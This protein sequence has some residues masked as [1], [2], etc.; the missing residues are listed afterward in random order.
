MSPFPLAFFP[1]TKH[2]RNAILA[3]QLEKNVTRSGPHPISLAADSLPVQAYILLLALLL[4]PHPLYPNPTTKMAPK[5]NNIHPS[6]HPTHASPSSSSSIEAIITSL[7]SRPDTA[8]AAATYHSSIRTSAAQ[9]R[10][11]LPSSPDPTSPAAAWLPIPEA[12]YRHASRFP[13]RVSTCVDLFH[14]IADTLECDTGEATVQDQEQRK[15]KQE[16]LDSIERVCQAEIASYGRAEKEEDV[17]VPTSSILLL[18]HLHAHSLLSF[19]IFDAFLSSTLSRATESSGG[20]LSDEQFAALVEV[21]TLN[22]PRI[23]ASAAPGTKTALERYVSQL[24]D[25]CEGGLGGASGQAFMLWALK[26]KMRD[27]WAGGDGE[28]GIGGVIAGVVE[29]GDEL[30]EYDE[31]VRELGEIREWRP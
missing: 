18:G 27:G 26:A 16:F 5:T 23:L 14:S 17:E 13:E 29:A 4:F 7:P 19:R 11:F 15:R 28:G 9:L 20:M 12:I 6:S 31:V 3:V 10:A 2:P 1:L 8:A 21:L 30:L 24:E 25:I 22:G